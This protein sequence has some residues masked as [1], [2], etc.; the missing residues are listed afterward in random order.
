MQA[1]NPVTCEAYVVIRLFSKSRAA[2]AIDTNAPP[3]S[4]PPRSR[5]YSPTG[6]MNTISRATPSVASAAPLPGRRHQSNSS[7]VFNPLHP[8]TL[9][10]F[11]I[12][13][14]RQHEM[15]AHGNKAWVCFLTPPILF[16]HCRKDLERVYFQFS[17]SRGKKI[18]KFPL[19]VCMWELPQLRNLRIMIG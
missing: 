1:S 5:E 12:Y 2:D 9:V 10:F 7:L 8:A 4:S 15:N 6:K 17:T 18:S 14:T 13:Q 11:R 16:A 3:V 19:T